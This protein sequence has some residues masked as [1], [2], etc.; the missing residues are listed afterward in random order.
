MPDYQA[1]FESVPGLNL[2]LTPELNIVAAS[3]AYRAATKAHEPLE[4]RYWSTTLRCTAAKLHAAVNAVG[5][6]AEDV[7]KYLVESRNV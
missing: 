6:N 2:V 3:D 5:T 4:V 1:I 7:R